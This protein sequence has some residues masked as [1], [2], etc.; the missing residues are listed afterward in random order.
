MG[1]WKRYRL[2]LPDGSLWSY[3]GLGENV[4]TPKG[5]KDICRAKYGLSAMSFPSSFG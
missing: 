5:P 4:F 2:I 3:G 1:S